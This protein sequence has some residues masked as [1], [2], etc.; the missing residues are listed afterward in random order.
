MSRPGLALALAATIAGLAA[1]AT[2][3]TE[4]DRFQVGLYG[5]L[6]PEPLYLQGLIGGWLG[7]ALT[8]RLRLELSGSWQDG[9]ESRTD[10]ADF[11]LDEALLDPDDPIAD[12]TV[13]TAE[14][15]LR[16]E[17]ARGKLAFLQST[18][19]GFAVHLGLGAGVRGRTGEAVDQVSPA[20][21]RAGGSDL[22]LGGM[23]RLR[24]D[25][26]GP[27]SLRRDDSVALGGEILLGVGVG[28]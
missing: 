18:L 28:L 7:A 2:A 5:G 26:R 27:A 19:G 4:P 11:L 23:V 10:L 20:A 22:R 9:L 24:F 8:P 14:A 15:L 1:P 12:R 6:G 13:F 3:G 25:L 16:F 17:P 21:I